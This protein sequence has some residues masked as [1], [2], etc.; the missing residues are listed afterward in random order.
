MA[1]L[2]YEVGISLLYTMVS[3][4]R[5]VVLGFPRVFL[6]ICNTA[7]SAHHARECLNG[8]TCGVV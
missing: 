3:S 4:V 6:R 8:T 7:E 5:S 2:P 1:C